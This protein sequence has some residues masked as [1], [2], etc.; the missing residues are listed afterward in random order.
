MGEGDAKGAGVARPSGFKTPETRAA[1]V[2]LYDEAISQSPVPVEESDVATS[3]GTTHVL[4]AGDPAKPPSVAMHA[5]SM[6]STMWLPLLPTLT[7]THH[8]RTLNR[9]PRTSNL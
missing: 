9:P 2:R 5:K 6:E 8:V 7:A 3:F 1:Y 4:T